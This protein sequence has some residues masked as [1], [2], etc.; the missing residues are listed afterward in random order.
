MAE[1]YIYFIRKHFSHMCLKCTC[2][3]CKHFSCTYFNCTHVKFAYLRCTFFS[4]RYFR[5][6]YFSLP[7]IINPLL[8]QWLALCFL[9]FLSFLVWFPLRT[10]CRYRGFLLRLIMLIVY[11][12]TRQWISLLR[13]TISDIKHSQERLECLCWWTDEIRNGYPNKRAT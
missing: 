9:F 8:M 5:C 11:D 13:I 12:S 7:N 6:T 3:I 4:R 1:V 2:L 10:H